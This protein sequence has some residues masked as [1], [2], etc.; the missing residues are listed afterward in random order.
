MFK[1]FLLIASTLLVGFMLF[2]GFQKMKASQQPKVDLYSKVPSSAVMVIEINQPLNLWNELLTNNI[3]LQEL[4][5]FREFQEMSSFISTVDSHLLILDPTKAQTPKKALISVS[6]TD[7]QEPYLLYQFPFSNQENTPKEVI[8]F[9]AKLLQMKVDMNPENDFAE[10]TNETNKLFIQVSPG[11]LSLSI[12]NNFISSTDSS[13][14]QNIEFTKIKNTSS[15]GTKI[16]FFFNPQNGFNLLSA[17]LS[18]KT[19][20]RIRSFATLSGWL[21]L[22]TEIKPDEIST[23]G[24]TTLTDSLNYHFEI[25]KNQAPVSP[26]VAKFLPARTAF[27]MHFG[28]SDFP[29]LRSVYVEQK[30]K[31]MGVPFDHQLI[32]WDTMYDISIENDFISWIDNEIALT[33]LEPEFTDFNDEIMVWVGSSDSR[34]L[35]QSLSE[36]ALKIDNKESNNFEIIEY[37]GFSI[38]KLNLEGF[39]Y[40]TLG[41]EFS[42]VDENYFTQIDDYIVF[43]NSPAT[44]QRTIN[45]LQKGQTLQENEYYQSF[46]NKMT[47]VSN[48]FIYSNIAQSPALYKAILSEKEKPNINKHKE[49]LQKFQAAAIKVSY[50]D[51]NLLFVNGYIKY[52]PI[53]KKERN[54]L[55]EI[56]LSSPANFKPVFVKNHYTKANEIFIQDTSNTIYL[57]DNKGAILWKRQLD[58]K[59]ISKVSQIDALKN[60]KLQLIFNTKASL[61]IIDRK[62]RD[63]DKFPVRLKSNASSGLLVA[64][65]SGTKDYRILIPTQNGS[66][67]NYTVN[68]KQ[69]KGWNYKS[70]NQIVNQPV[71]YIKIKNKDYLIVFYDDGGLTALDR[72]GSIRIDLKSRFNFKP[73]GEIIVQLGSDLNKTH[74]ICT[75][76]NQEVVQISLTDKKTRLFSIPDDSLQFI[77]YTSKSSISSLEIMASG[78]SSISVYQTDGNQISSFN[79]K[80][81]ASTS[82]QLYHFNNQVYTGFSNTSNDLLYI[83]SSRGN[84]VY[85]FPLKGSSPFS[86]ADLNND[87]RL[88]LIVSDKNGIL[89]NYSLE[90]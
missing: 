29:L 7:E 48:L 60:N 81:N 68:G 58:G 34:T 69:V 6:F 10:L 62:G 12:D 84:I 37:R 82:P 28:F 70:T 74:V 35:A 33:I 52:N 30:T 38:Q 87:G 19:N 86:I 2:F 53:Y 72:R 21:E 46:T 89:Y 9:W 36:M 63:L 59:I 41:E 50:E 75:T 20:E 3:I 57:I 24:F 39:L 1:K 40:A 22:D 88:N 80:T 73:I 55:W 42:A 18:D 71:Q 85:P 15:K 51:D 56:P 11:I 16:R 66:I 5:E 14:L 90:E 17:T 32:T 78:T 47:D 76:K 64:D 23:S 77:T 31:L 44:L 26:R 4:K 83:Y 61:Y 43:A 67:L 8:N 27:L 25:F 49:W 54:S 45:K 13:I 65:Y 79:P